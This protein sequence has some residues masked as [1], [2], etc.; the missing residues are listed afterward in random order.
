M[1]MFVCL[2]VCM[3]VCMFICLYVYMFICFICV[4]FCTFVRFYVKLLLQD[5]LHLGRQ[6]VRG[7]STTP[8]PGHLR[9]HGRVI[10]DPT[11]GSC[12]TPRSG[13][14]SFF[15]RNSAPI[16]FYTKNKLPSLLLSTIA[17]YANNY[18]KFINVMRVF[19]NAFR[20]FVKRL[21]K[22]Y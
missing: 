16:T 17:R 19:F 15:S 14:L 6:I 20:R 21:L 2:Y 9:P 7:S 8:R 11:A 5:A 22:T 18:A 1:S 12:T 10:Y 3:Y 13:G 4:Y